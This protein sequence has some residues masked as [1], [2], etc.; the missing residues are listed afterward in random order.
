[1]GFRVGGLFV[2]SFNKPVSYPDLFGPQ[3]HEVSFCECLGCRVGRRGNP[4][5]GNRQGTTFMNLCSFMCF[6]V[7]NGNS[8][9]AV[10]LQL[11]KHGS[12]W[13]V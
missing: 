4:E 6:S 1:M 2:F 9:E 3:D 11:Y 7:F 8:L 13:R 10:K 12:I 5:S